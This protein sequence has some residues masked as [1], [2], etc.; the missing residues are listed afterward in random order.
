MRRTKRN[1]KRN[2]RTKRRKG[3]RVLDNLFGPPQVITKDDESVVSLEPFGVVSKTNVW[4]SIIVPPYLKTIESAKNISSRIDDIIKGLNSN[5]F[6]FRCNFTA[7]VKDRIT[8]LEMYNNNV[9]KQLANI[10]STDNFDYEQ[11]FSNFKEIQLYIAIC[12][13][14]SV[15]R[16]VGY[17]LFGKVATSLL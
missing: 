8:K 14:Q 3:G 4:S 10:K 11:L 16:G 7:R 17:N 15:E 5:G 12:K 1:R 6:I 13:S 9:K 2:G